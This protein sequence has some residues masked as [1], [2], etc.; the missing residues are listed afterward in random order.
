M[1]P[2]V[3]IADHQEIVISGLKGVLADGGIEVVATAYNSRELLKGISRQL[4][5]VAIVGVHLP[6][7][8]G[9]CPVSN[10]R[11]RFPDVRIIALGAKS[12]LMPIRKLSLAGAHGYAFTSAGKDHLIELI[13]A[14]HT[15]GHSGGLKHTNGADQEVFAIDDDQDAIRVLSLTNR[16]VHYLRLLCEE[17][18]NKEI[19]QSLHVS[20]RTT[21]GWSKALCEKLGVRSRLGLV[22]F[23]VRNGIV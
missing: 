4:P 21:E 6:S 10:I 14:V 1:R 19:A 18:T 13:H 15:N 23:S 5:D 20:P 16:E 11:V 22:A 3:A 12:D 2:K 7:F 17:M 8:D 9:V